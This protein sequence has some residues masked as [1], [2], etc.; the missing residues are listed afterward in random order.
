M[1]KDM[2]A[3]Y[4]DIWSNLTQGVLVVAANENGNH[5]VQEAIELAGHHIT[6]DGTYTH[7]LKFSYSY[8]L[9]I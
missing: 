4:N 1:E 5:H 7:S 8:T 9:V 2:Q 6:D 3:L